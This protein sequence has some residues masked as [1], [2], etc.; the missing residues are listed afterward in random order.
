MKL[1]FICI[2]IL[3]DVNPRDDNDAWEWLAKITDFPMNKNDAKAQSHAA[4]NKLWWLMDPIH[5]PRIRTWGIPLGCKI[6]DICKDNPKWPS[7]FTKVSP[8][9]SQRDGDWWIYDKNQDGEHKESAADSNF[10]FLKK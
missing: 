10:Y 3:K 6:G 4:L 1:D 8:I 5:H 9:S 2:Y 7:E